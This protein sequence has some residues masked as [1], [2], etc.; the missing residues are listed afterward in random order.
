[1][2]PTHAIAQAPLPRRHSSSTH[3]DNCQSN[4]EC[5]PPAAAAAVNGARK[6]NS[7]AD[8]AGLAEALR[9]SEAEVLCLL[10]LKTHEASV[11]MEIRGPVWQQQ[12]P[13]A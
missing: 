5:M 7:A 2:A 11:C 1:M 3:H 8:A 6:K 12:Q 4:T 13:V 10:E 9:R